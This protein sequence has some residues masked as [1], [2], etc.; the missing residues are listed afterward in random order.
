[1]VLQAMIEDIVGE[2]FANYVSKSVLKPIGAPRATFAIT[3]KSAFAFGSFE[4]GRPVEGGYRRHPE[5]AAAGLWATASDLVTIFQAILHSLRGARHAILPIGLAE[6][7][8]T[9]VK[10]QAGL[11][12]FV[13][14]GRAI[15]HEGRNF[16]FD[17]VVA[18][19]LSTGQ[20]RAAV[21]NRNGA[22]EN[23]TQRL[24]AQ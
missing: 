19:D 21:T 6:R 4:N 23:Y 12:V 11:G 13:E 14:P 15:W 1:M 5:S 7:M 17:A 22:I 18:A 3:P 16:G 2:E 20:I 9:P 10:Q 8:I 24:L